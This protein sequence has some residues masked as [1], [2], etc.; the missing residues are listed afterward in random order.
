MFEAI[1]QKGRLE[2]LLEPVSAIVDECKIHLGDGGVTITAVDASNVALVDVQL[3]AEA[4]EA[5][6]ADGGVIAVNINRLEDV[7]GEADGGAL[8]QLRL[9]DETRKLEIAFDRVDFELALL[10]PETVR[11]EPELPDLDLPATVGLEG[12]HLAQAVKLTSMVADHL[13]LGVDTT[14]GVFYVRSEGDTDQVHIEHPGDELRALTPADVE[15]LFSLEYLDD[16]Q[17]TIPK[18]AEVTLRLGEAMPLKLDFQI[19]EAY[20]DCEFML[21]P[22]LE[23]E[24]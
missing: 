23:G 10:D 12:R 14:A 6:E 3:D 18:E 9:D 13:V 8:V 5:Y 7:V 11:D 16:I 15:S 20:G 21:S 1:I 22:R 4:F 2:S 17:T 24:G 19:A